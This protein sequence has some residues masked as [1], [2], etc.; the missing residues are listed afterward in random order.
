MF[1]RLL[2]LLFVSLLLPALV[3]AQDGKLRGKITD[4]ATG[5]ALVG[6]NVFVEGTSLGA[7]ADINGEYIV[8]SVPAGVYSVRVTFVGYAPLTVANV[9]V[10]ANITTT[11]DFELT[12]TA[13]QVEGIEIVAERPLI[14]RN[15]TNT[16]RLATQEDIENLPLRGVQNIIALNA[17]VVQQDDKLYIRGGRAGEVAYFVEGANTTNPINNRNNV[18]LIQEALEEVQLQ[19]GGY[20]AEHGGSN[21]GIARATIRTGTPNFTGSLD[22][23]SDDFAKP[24]EEFLGTSSFGW[25]NVVLTVGGPIVDNMRFFV[26]GQHNYIRSG[27]MKFIE[28]F[29][30]EGLVDEL[31]GRPLPGPVEFLRN[32]VPK[33]SQQNNT[34]QGTLTYDMNPLKFRLSGSYDAFTTPLSG[35]WPNTL[36]NYFNLKRSLIDRTRASFGSLRATH[37]IGASSYYDITVSYQNRSFTREDPDFGENWKSYVDSA[38]NA[39]LGYTGFPRRFTHPTDMEYSVINAFK[40]RHENAPNNT[41]RKNQQTSLGFAG[42]FTSQVESNWELKAGGRLDLWTTRHFNVGN[43]QQAMLTLFNADGTPRVYA[44][45][46]ERR[47]TVAHGTRGGNINHYGYDV[48]GNEV[49]DGLDAPRKPTFLSGYV[50]N[51]LELQDLVLNVGLRVERFDTKAKVFRNPLAPDFDV[52]NDIVD[53]S[54]L[55]EADAFTL[56]LPRINLAFPV[57]DRTVFYSQY[58]KYAQLPALNQLYV[59]NVALSR[60]IS[61]L[62]RGNAFLTPV[63]WLMK[64]ERTTQYEMGLRQ[65]VTENFAFTVS[66]FYKDL[67]DQLQV[68]WYVTDA[69]QKLFSA[70]QNEDFGTVKGLELTLELR[71]TH[72]LWARVN[73]TLS[74]AQGT[75]SNSQSSFGAV[76]QNIGRPTNFINPLNFNQTH[77]GAVLLDYRWGK[78]DGGPVLSGLGANLV[79]SF[80]SGHNYTKI[81]EVEELGQASPWNVGVRPLLDPRSSFPTEPL[82]S[83]RTP[84]VFNVDLAVSK[85]FYLG[86]IDLS[87]YVNI[88]NLLNTKQI[89]NVYPNTGTAQDDGWL[90]SPF[91]ASYEAIPNYAA[92]YRAI[93]LQNRW[94]YAVA[95][96]ND[97]LGSPVGNDLFGSPRQVRLG[98][99]LEL[100]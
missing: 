95:T 81:K 87:I 13:V 21:S 61:E 6:A 35:Q 55:I 75:G 38:A 68:R 4:K 57:S 73:Y 47:A 93:N 72:R 29:K 28:P 41:Y 99:K 100:R 54:K 11:Q 71:R 1:R 64:P 69:G 49:D 27:Q 36:T 22:V 18:A 53:E 7:A 83:S 86:G 85:T 74:D 80:N 30:F 66:G 5:E 92:F 52:Q 12:S 9:R 3:V 39:A 56:W 76:E 51:K 88:L 94:A 32:H 37:V 60:T 63:G 2:L 77:R 8:L 42:D 91:A 96:V 43:I 84:W 67:K 98:M 48:D 40:F 59:G 62:T 20:T 19:S 70:Y 82:N 78:D 14:Q 23:Q 15:T 31:D 16:V 17:G 26:A 90:G 33:S 46:E 79:L 50:Q 58:G 97:V 45:P 89:L 34:V 10:S 24:G 25:R 65:A 44:S